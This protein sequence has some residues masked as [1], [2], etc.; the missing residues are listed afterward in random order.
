MQSD[1]DS[2]FFTYR[3]H[4]DQRPHDDHLLRDVGLVRNAY[5]DIAWAEDPT[6]LVPD[7]QRRSIWRR[8]LAMAG[9]AM[10]GFARR[11]KD[12]RRFASGKA[13]AMR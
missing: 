6:R 12:R 10:G 8:I 1:W 7:L 9:K 3:P 5:G 13:S 2:L 4:A 11:Y